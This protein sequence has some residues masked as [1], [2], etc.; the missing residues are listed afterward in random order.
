MKQSILNIK[1]SC[2]ENCNGTTPKDINLLTWLNSDKHRGKVEEIRSIQD[3]GIQKAIKKTLP[4]ITPCGLFSYRDE[5]HLIEHSGFLVFDIDFADNTHISNFD[6]L[7]EQISHVIC[8]AYCGLSVRGKG[9]WGLVPITIS[10]PEVHKYRFNA[11]SNF[12]KGYHIN[13]DPSGK[14]I[15]RLRIYSFDADGYFNHNAKLYTGILKPQ[16]KKS[17][18]PTYSDTRDRVEAI[19]ELIKSNHT[20][21]T[22]GYEVWL[23]I[24]CSLANEF[25]ESG[26]GYFHAVSSY[27]SKYTPEGT[28][29]M[30]DNVM[31]HD[32]TQIS[33]GSF[34]HIAQQYGIKAIPVFQQTGI[35]KTDLTRREPV[36]PINI[37]PEVKPGIWTPDIQELEQFFNTAK[38]PPA[39]KLNQCSTIT[40]IDLFIKSHLD[41]VKGQN[42]NLRYIPYLDRLRLLKTLLN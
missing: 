15:C 27:N 42:G 1:V 11:L 21:I 4:A 25:G 32:Y 36:A 39:I 17:T 24:G 7:K 26:R 14:D 40:N 5:K 6:T 2:F 3:E 29:R 12:F 30:F 13:L 10:T 19:I 31:K 18:R 16:P 23:K 35:T 8:V 41:I 34:F 20:D 38:L 28:D 9:F 33:I 22:E 37:Q